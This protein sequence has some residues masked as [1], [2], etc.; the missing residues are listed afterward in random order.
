MNTDLLDVDEQFGRDGCALRRAV[1]LL[2][3]V[4]SRKRILRDFL[5]IFRR[6]FISGT[7]GCPSFRRPLLKAYSR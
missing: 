3:S 1:L 4:S 2:L 5:S 6:D 7:L